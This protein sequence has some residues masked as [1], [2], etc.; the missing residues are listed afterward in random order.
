MRTPCVPSLTA[1]GWV[2]DP[3]AKLDL[4]FA[5]FLASNYSQSEVFEGKI[6][7]LPYVIQQTAG[8]VDALRREAADSLQ[9]HLQKLFEKVSVSTDVR[10]I[11]TGDGT[12]TTLIYK[13]TIVDDGK[14]VVFN[15]QIEDIR[16]SSLKL[17]VLNNG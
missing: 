14:A 2:T 7:S 17:I 11:N 1:G 13:I 3:G 9:R 6:S 4:A 16:S 12:Y 10:D 15:R 5:D 8:K